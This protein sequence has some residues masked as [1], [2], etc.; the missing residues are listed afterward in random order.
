MNEQDHVPPPA[1]G[2]RN[3]RFEAAR[4]W[5]DA[6]SLLK[7]NRQILTVLAGLFFLVPQVLMNALLPEVRPDLEGEAAAKAAIAIFGQWW[8]L[9]VLA[10]LMQATGLIA[11]VVLLADRAR[12]TVG[13]AIRR[14][15]Q[16]LPAYVAAT[17]VLMA[18]IVLFALMVMVPLTLVGGQGGAAIAIVP[19]MAAALWI[20][21]RTLVLAPV[22]AAEQSRNPFEALRRS[23][24]LT[25]GKGARILFFLMLFVVAALVISIVATAVPG[26]I[27]IAALGQETGGAIVGLI[28]G[29]VSAAL[30]MV[31]SAVIVAVYRQL[32]G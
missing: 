5:N 21:I 31:W 3:T 32:A 24:A 1:P 9:I 30:I 20:N 16:C 19:I 10:T 17:L 12:P 13:D 7:A 6:M 23:W 4:A 14:A 22:I 26:T 15:L 18:G 29:F 8:P 28:E 27:L 2:N 11:I 25:A